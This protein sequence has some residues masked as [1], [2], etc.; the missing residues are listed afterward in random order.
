MHFMNNNMGLIFV[1]D[2]SFQN[3]AYG[4]G[5]VLYALVLM[6]ILH[7]PFLF[8]RVFQQ[9]APSEQLETLWGK[10]SRQRDKS[11]SRRRMLR[12]CGSLTVEKL[13]FTV[14]AE[15]QGRGRGDWSDECRTT[16]GHG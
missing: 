15:T 9:K 12:V 7:L 10:S 14:P 2:L 4:W 1:P 5:E 16:R 11:K 13:L 3:Q 8:S 6:A